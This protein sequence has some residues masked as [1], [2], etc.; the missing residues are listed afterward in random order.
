MPGKAKVA[1]K[2]METL[3]NP[4]TPALQGLAQALT[5][6]ALSAVT[7]K[8]E[9]TI[10]RLTTFNEGGGSSFIGALTGLGSSDGGK[11]A[12]TA[13]LSGAKEAIKSKVGGAKSG[14]SGKLKVTNI[15][16]T[17]DIGAPVRVVYNQWTQFED[18]S[19]FMK[20]IENVE[21]ESDEE[22]NWKAQIFLSHR[23]WEAQIIEQVPDK[24]IIWRSK[25]QKGHVDG[26]VTFHALTPDLTRVV[27]VLEYYPQGMFER[28][29]NLWRAQGRRVRLEL[30]HFHRHVMTRTML[31]PD[32]MEGSGWRGVI[33]EGE[34]VKDHETALR[35]EQEEQGQEEA[36]FEEEEPEEEFE[37]E[38][39]PEEEEE[40][41]EE[42]RRR[43]ASGRGR[44]SRS[45]SRETDE[46]EPEEEEEEEKPRR[47]AASGRGR[48]VR[49]T[50]RETDEEPEEEEE[51]RPRRRAASAKRSTR[52]QRQQDEEPSRPTRRRAAAQRG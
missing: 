26:A 43:T 19:N 42:P 41:E 50:S 27:L 21:Q 31:N 28:M 47:R 3:P 20:K 18:F 13:L 46:E 4:L 37:E 14:K 22:I 8:V 35:E 24:R 7:G 36:E 6:R 25:G 51:D 40:E 15:V 11:S 45:T 52:R 33:H 2:A 29:G 23:G 38:E 34:V 49:S 9:A 44:T 12:G 48:T 30:K 39:E 10:E 17:I 16:E 32:E 1:G 5:E